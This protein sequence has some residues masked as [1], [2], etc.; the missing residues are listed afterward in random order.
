MYETIYYH[1]F[2]L[3][4]TAKSF[5][6]TKIF[7]C[8]LFNIITGTGLLCSICFSAAED[9]HN[10][11][12]CTNLIIRVVGH[13]IHSESTQKHTIITYSSLFKGELERGLKSTAWY[14][15]KSCQ[16]HPQIQ[17]KGFSAE[18]REQQ[19]TAGKEDG[20]YLSTPTNS[21]EISIETKSGLSIEI[22]RW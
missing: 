5:L 19:L 8:T 6:R 14:Q 15:A 2:L 13:S 12:Q 9:L 22:Q 16:V 4:N 3:S 1:S 7:S 18:E 21:R 10:H 20:R 11:E 17:W